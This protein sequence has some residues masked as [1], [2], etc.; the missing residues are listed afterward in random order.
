MTDSETEAREVCKKIWKYEVDKF[1]PLPEKVIAAAIQKAE[2]RGKQYGI[3][4]NHS[5]VQNMCENEQAARDE[6]KKVLTELDA[7]GDS[8][9]VPMIQGVMD[10]AIKA[11]KKQGLL[12]AAEIAEAKIKANEDRV[13]DN[14]M[15]D[16]AQAI[17]EEA[18]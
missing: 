8:W 6:A 12:K 18:K 16:I 17:R 15:K 4:L 14:D 10:E 1:S 9:G 3:S 11:A 13:A 2:D 7:E 5:V